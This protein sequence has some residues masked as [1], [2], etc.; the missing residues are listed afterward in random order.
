MIYFIYFEEVGIS[1]CLQLPAAATFVD[2]Y[3]LVGFFVVVWYY[4]YYYYI[5][6]YLQACSEYQHSVQYLPNVIALGIFPA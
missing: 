1:C 6:V 5:T 2:F 3:N 4:Y